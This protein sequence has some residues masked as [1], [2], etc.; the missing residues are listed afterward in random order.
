MADPDEEKL[1]K[2]FEVRAFAVERKWRGKRVSP[3]DLTDA[4]FV[5]WARV[6]R[7]QET[8]GAGCSINPCDH[9]CGDDGN[10]PTPGG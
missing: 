10:E 9:C 6:K 7:A 1:K 5:A 8:M 2:A 4:D 3:L